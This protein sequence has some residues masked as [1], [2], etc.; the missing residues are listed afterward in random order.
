MEHAAAEYTGPHR[1]FAFPTIN[2]IAAAMPARAASF[3]RLERHDFERKS[4]VTTKTHSSTTSLRSALLAVLVLVLGSAWLPGSRASAQL[5]LPL[6]SLVVTVTAPADRATVSG[7][8]TVRA[9]V[10]IIGALTVSSVQFKLDGHAIGA[11]DTSAPYSIA[12]D[13]RTASNGLHN[14]TA[15]ARDALGVQWESQA[16]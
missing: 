13:T 4:A 8:T 2:V 9:Q 14:L 11:P 7:T 5:G 3:A 16:I 12:W 15:W 10:S 1:P 6:G